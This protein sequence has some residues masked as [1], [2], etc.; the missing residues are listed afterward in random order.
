[1]AE[2]MAELNRT[3]NNIH[4]DTEQL[5]GTWFGEPLY[6]KSFAIDNPT[7][8]MQIL[9]G[10]TRA[11]MSNI[12]FTQQNGTK[13]G[14]YNFSSAYLLSIRPIIFSGTTNVVI[15]LQKGTTE[16]PIT[17][18]EFDLYFTKL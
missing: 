16:S 4:S 11:F 10:A 6:M 14:D 8:G 13:Q 18:V 1:M 7:D 12:M 15:G 17:K 9:S 3:N 2:H 5:V